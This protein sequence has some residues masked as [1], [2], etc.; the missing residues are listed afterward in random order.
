MLIRY[1]SLIIMWAGAHE[2]ERSSLQVGRYDGLTN[3]PDY[4]VF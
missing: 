4:H 2:I 1:F 3:M